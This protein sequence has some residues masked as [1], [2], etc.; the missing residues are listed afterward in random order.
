MRL[1]I[2]LIRPHNL[3]VDEKFHILNYFNVMS[4]ASFA[5]FFD[6]IEKIEGD[7]VECGIGR[8]RSLLILSALVAGLKL[9]R[10]I[11]GYDS[12]AGFPEPSPHDMSERNPQKGEWSHSPSQKY[13]YTQEFCRMVLGQADIPLDEI[14]FST[15]KGFFG[16]TLPYNDSVNIALLNID[17]DLY[18]SY[19]DVLQNLYHKVSPGGV[20]I[21][22]DFA[23]QDN[24]GFFPG[25]RLA[26]KEFLGE[27]LYGSIR[28]NK[29][30][31]YYLV[32]PLESL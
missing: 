21:F 32:K 18:Q 16:D 26:V 10:R 4:V 12:F 24:R 17:G 11:L 23:E 2:D 31:A 9:N 30:G 6:F 1:L 5:S 7:I 22:D 8:S 15:I 29:Y 28:I 20:I 19:M 14:N 25:A 13:Q 27:Q 3:D